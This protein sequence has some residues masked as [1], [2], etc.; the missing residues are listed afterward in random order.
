MELNHKIHVSNFA[1]IAYL[2]SDLVFFF[3]TQIS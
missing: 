3:Q 1:K 2:L